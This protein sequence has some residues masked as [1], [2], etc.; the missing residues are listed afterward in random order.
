VTSRQQGGAIP[1]RVLLVEDDALSLKL[2]SDVLEAHGYHVTQATNGIDGLTMA[3]EGSP[4]LIVM[5]I[6]L[7]AMDGVEVTRSLKADPSVSNVPVVA[8]TAYAMPGDEERMRSAGCDAFLTKPLRF[9]EF[10]EVVG[11]LLAAASA[12]SSPATGSEK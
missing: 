8:V 6:G 5:D 9:S 11:R 3:R 12:Q 2:M 4:D 10:V 1:G 7:P